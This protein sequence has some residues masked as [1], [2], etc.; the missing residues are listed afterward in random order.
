[1]SLVLPN[2][3]LFAGGFGVGRV[4]NQFQVV[5]H[6]I[7]GTDEVVLLRNRE[8]EIIPTGGP[9]Q[10][11]RLESGNIVAEGGGKVSFLDGVF[12]K[13]PLFVGLGRERRFRGKRAPGGCLGLKGAKLDVADHG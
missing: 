4:G 1:M 2:D 13:D 3:Q 10:L 6:A 9:Q 5:T 8:G 7:G 11:L 12:S